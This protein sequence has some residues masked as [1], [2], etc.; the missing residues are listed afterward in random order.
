MANEWDKYELL[1]EDDPS[2]LT[3]A[4]DGSDGSGKSYFGCTA[5]GP[6]YV[7]GFDPHGMSRV[8]KAVRSGKEIRIG[9]YGFNGGIYTKREDAKKAADG[10]WEKFKVDYRVALKNVRT[11]LW[12][13]E[14]LAW[15]LLRYAAFGGQKN[16]GSKTGALDYGDLNAEY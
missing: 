15:E 8:D 4:S 2:S 11:V 3:W 12:D 16:E 14:D 6:I 5:P 10:I 9:R 13:R 1:S 7:C